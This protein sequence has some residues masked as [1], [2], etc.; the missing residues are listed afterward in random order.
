MKKPNFYRLALAGLTLLCVLL[1]V[2]CVGIWTEGERKARYVLEL[3][4]Q[5]NDVMAK[6]AVLT[7]GEKALKYQ[8]FYAK[9]LGVHGYSQRRISMSK[10]QKANFI[11]WTYRLSYL[12]SLPPFYL[13]AK[14]VME[15]NFN[16]RC[17]G[18]I[19]EIGVFQHH[20][21]CFPSLLLAIRQLHAACPEIAKEVDPHLLRWGDLKDPIKSL[22]AQAIYAWAL[23]REYKDEIFWI[24]ASHWGGFRV[25]PWYYGRTEP[26]DRWTFYNKDNIK[27]IDSRS[28]LLYYFHW[29]GINSNF[30]RFNLDL[31]TYCREYRAYRKKVQREERRYI[32]ARRLISKLLKMADRMERKEKEFDRAIEDVKRYKRQV[33]GLDQDFRKIYGLAKRDKITYKQAFRRTRKRFQVW[34][35]KHLRGGKE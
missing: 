2:F 31:G 7:P 34:L 4:T 32:D 22:K 20:R 15:S 1:A 24:S 16:P 8:K 14:A 21:T 13:M 6:D 18:A 25:A 17:E 3:M 27:K 33:K 11:R 26:K 9:I 5:V 30:E 10:M 35:K 28:P 29:K 23:K 19:G 12:L